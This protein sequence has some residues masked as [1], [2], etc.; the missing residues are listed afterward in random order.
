M[1]EH[2]FNF[3]NDFK[4]ANKYWNSHFRFTADVHDRLNSF[5][6]TNFSG[7]TVLGVHYRGTDKNV[8][9]W[10][11]NPVSRYQFLCV[12][13]DFLKSHP[14]VT[15]IFVA[16]DD[17]KFIEAM[18]NFS[19][20]RFYDQQRS[21]DGRPLWNQQKGSGNEAASKDA[22]LDSLTLARC[23]YGLKCMSQLSAFSKV[24]NPELEIYRVSAC[25]P[26]WFPEAYVPLYRSADRAAQSLLNTLQEGDFQA[27]PL[28]KILALPR[29]LSGIAEQWQR[30]GTHVPLISR[31]LSRK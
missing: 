2:K 30:R 1:S 29:R 10:Q 4:R 11:A 9:T 15:A 8:D 19:N 12:V 20:A 31:L 14:D 16:S 7:K 28:S 18:R 23:R 22:I 21:E 24:I 6:E 26:G 17:A 25:K 27:P 5:W 13:E 3:K